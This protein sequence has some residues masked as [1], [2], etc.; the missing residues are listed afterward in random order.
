MQI[1]IV[2]LEV[3]F[4]G[5]NV[6]GP[7]GDNSTGEMVEICGFA[8]VWGLDE[9]IK[10]DESFVRFFGDV[11]SMYCI[12]YVGRSADVELTTAICW[13]GLSVVGV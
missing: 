6:D 8:V 2:S 10:S 11:H 1:S 5:A 12:C 7:S 9:I 4:R 3:D 13:Y